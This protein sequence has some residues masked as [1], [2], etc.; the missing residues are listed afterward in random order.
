MAA[1]G[2]LAILIPVRCLSQPTAA[3]EVS[4]PSAAPAAFER[5]LAKHQDLTY[6]EWRAALGE[7][8]PAAS[9]L[10]FDPTK[11]KYFD[12]IQGKLKLTDE[13]LS[14]F[15]RTGL[16]AMDQKLRH[17]F[18]SAYYQI[19][20]SD[21]PVLI[22]TDSILHALHRS[23]D[24]LLAEV[25][26][27]WFAVSMSEILA[28]CHS[29]LERLRLARPNPDLSESL[30]DV[31]L[32]LSVARNLFAGAGAPATSPY[33]PWD[34]DEW[35][36]ELLIHSVFGQDE[37]VLTRLRDIQSGVIQ[38]PF[39]DQPTRIYGGRRFVDY[40]QFRPRG[41][42]AKSSELRRYFRAM[43]WMGR[44]D[45]G[46]N[47][48]PS[49]TPG[50][51]AGSD[52][53]LRDAIL[54]TQLIESSGGLGRLKAIDDLL[55]L[56]VGQSDNLG[57][58]RLKDLLKRCD[59]KDGESLFDA[60]AV[61]RLKKALEDG[62]FG[63]QWIRSQAVISGTDDPHKLP[64]PSTFMVFGQRFAL[65]SFILSHVVFDSIIFQG[66]KQ[67]RMIPQGLDVMAV[68]GNDEAA[69]LLDDE[70][71]RWNYGANLLASREFVDQLQPRF[72][73]Q[74]LYNGWLDALRTLDD[75]LSREENSPQAM[76]TTAW[77]RKQLQ[78]Q[79]AS[80]SELRHDNV[81]YAKP[82]YTGVPA[83]EYPDGYV[84]PYPR[85]YAS[86]KSLAEEAL[87]CLMSADYGSKDPQVCRI[88]VDV[89]TRQLD[90]LR[91]MTRILGRL[92]VV[93]RK[94]LRA[95]PLTA[96]ERG[97]LERTIDQRGT[98][99][100][101]SGRRPRYDGWYC[102]LLY[103]ASEE[104]PISVDDPRSLDWGPTVVDIH[105]DPESR[106]VLEA[107]V[108]DVNLCVIAIDN[109][110]EKAVYVGPIFSY[111]EFRH[112][113]E[114][115]LTDE[116]WQTMIVNDGLP[117]PPEWTRVFRARPRIRTGR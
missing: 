102:D 66:R 4:E 71:R 85:F 25:E 86:L 28:D 15:R 52:R 82:S 89:K 65:D 37:E 35:N 93:A 107:G 78:T 109:R 18:A 79:L 108:G 44:A 98:V 64:P 38:V 62:D 59:I 63:R 43:S 20:T 42:Y 81:L 74:N 49:R 94:E 88:L 80:W 105:T 32:F 106:S 11:Q 31:D 111:Y 33:P 101:G 60:H 75:D 36:G 87:K 114:D 95:E 53:E 92:E 12:L 30:R 67:K 103:K 58:F 100:W 24:A 112:P 57:V 5:I 55:T 7:H 21:L 99:R 91:T 2:F 83:C 110:R 77:R 115:R 9:S 41:H 29:E 68:L 84:E 19:Y 117:S 113:A 96:E 27:D 56:L 16:V 34:R 10:S 47:V 3:Q 54:L 14:M 40:S 46:W 45:C 97:F 104:S 6:A 61:A 1:A 39:Q 70:V 50:A 13:E 69:W 26:T 48:L 72:W 22:T 23:Y 8:P 116:R 51:L 73:R 76:R 17:S 90:Y